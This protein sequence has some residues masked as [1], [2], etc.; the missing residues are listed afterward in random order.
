MPC[1]YVFWACAAPSSDASTSIRGVLELGRCSSFGEQFYPFSAFLVIFPVSTT[2]PGLMVAPIFVVDL[3]VGRLAKWLRVICYDSL[4]VPDADDSELLRIA[5]EQDRTLITKDR[6]IM[7]RRLVTTRQVRA[8][9]IESDDFREQMQQVS[10]A[11]GLHLRDV[12]TLCI[13]CNKP[14]RRI[15]KVKVRDRVPPFVFGTQE[16]FFECPQC[17]KLYW[18]GT[19]WRNMRTEMAGFTEGE[20]DG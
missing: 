13:E 2:Q 17:A 10:E 16:Q 5:R 19:H 14:L 20:L 6:Y 9:L 15:A 8:L 7:E 3:N 4:F 1:P 18:R 11:M 12:F